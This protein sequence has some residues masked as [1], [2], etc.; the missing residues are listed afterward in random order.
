MFSSLSELIKPPPHEHAARRDTTVWSTHAHKNTC[1]NPCP[2]IGRRASPVSKATLGSRVCV[3]APF[4]KELH[5]NKAGMC[6]TVRSVWLCG[7]QSVTV[8][9]WPLGLHVGVLP[10]STLH[11]CRPGLV[12][13][14]FVAWN[15]QKYSQN[16]FGR[17]CRGSCDGCVFTFM[18]GGVLPV[19]N[20]LI[21]QHGKAGSSGISVSEPVLKHHKLTTIHV[22]FTGCPV[23][24]AAVFVYPRSLDRTMWPVLG[25]QLKVTKVQKD[26]ALSGTQQRWCFT[27]VRPRGLDLS[28]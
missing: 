28:K 15:Y 17:R 9:T 11:M 22:T 1:H 2:P 21:T 14:Y 16:V 4:R 5:V 7:K 23:F 27:T 12:V 26:L 13:W 19:Q 3:A 25:R 8:R 20:K 6:R 10:L 18:V 24:C